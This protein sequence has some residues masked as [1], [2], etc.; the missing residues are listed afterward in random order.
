MTRIEQET[1]INFNEA[2]DFADVY[3]YNPRLLRRLDELS[4][5]RPGDVQ[6]QR[7]GCK[8]ASYRVPKGWIRI[9][10][11]RIGIRLTEEQRQERAER[12]RQARKFA[13]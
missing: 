13:K 5:E 6:L 11:S 12:L 3:T 8:N 4:R 9:N 1:I 2:E 7:A 10:P